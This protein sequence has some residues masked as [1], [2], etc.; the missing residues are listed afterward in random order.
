MD[1]VCTSVKWDH[2]QILRLLCGSNGM[3]NVEVLVISKDT[4]FIIIIIISILIIAVTFTIISSNNNSK[5][6]N[7]SSNH[8]S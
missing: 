8:D 3:V 4:I 7:H 2:N 1:Q 6:R 5:S